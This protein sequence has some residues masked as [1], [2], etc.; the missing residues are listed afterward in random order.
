MDSK[1]LDYVLPVERDDVEHVYNKKKN[2]YIKRVVLSVGIVIV[3]LILIAVL[4]FLFPKSIEGSW[5]LVVNPEVVQATPDEIDDSNNAYYTFSKPGDYGDG[6]WT[7]YFDG[8]VEKGDYKLSHKVDKE[9]INMGSGEFEYV[10]TGSKL[11]GNAK[12]V[13][14]YPEY[15]D[16]ATGAVTPTQEYIF[17]QDKAPKYSDE[18]YESYHI[19][20]SLLGEWITNE[21]TL[22]YSVYSLS[23]VESVNFAENGNLVFTDD[24]TNGSIFADEF[25]STVTYYT[26][27]NLPQDTTKNV[28][29]TE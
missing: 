27:E 10:I 23:Y 18:S 14:T 16:D 26:P 3:V 17:E 13:I 2:M 21:R 22:A 11:L 12:L 19:D 5:A 4:S 28:S 15:T 25:F 6:E 7:T 1:D 20:K 24:N 8:G 9:Y 29:E